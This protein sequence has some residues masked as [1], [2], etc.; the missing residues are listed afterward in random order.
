MATAAGPLNCAKLLTHHASRLNLGVILLGAGAST[1][2]GRPKLLLPWGTTSVLGHLIAQWR[3]LRAKQI[4]VVCAAGG[5]LPAELDRLAVGPQ[6]RILNPHPEQ[7]MFS[8]IQCA[9][10]WP[11]WN[12]DITHWAIALGDQPHLRPDTL[13]ALLVFAAAHPESIC[14]PSRYARPRHPVL[15]PAGAF[16][17][18]KDSCDAHLKQFLRDSVPP[19]QLCELDDPGL[20]LDLDQPSDYEAALKLAA[21]QDEHGVNP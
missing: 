6:D 10:R 18:L 1:R 17:R 12:A 19:V 5:T 9:A 4:A 3:T 13:R 7:G 11:G 16:A 15:L 21:R 20:D 2:M 14:Q 8:S